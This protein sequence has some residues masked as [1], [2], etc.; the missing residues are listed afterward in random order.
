[1]FGLVWIPDAWT[2]RAISYSSEHITEDSPSL[3][4]Q[5]HWIFIYLGGEGKYG[6]PIM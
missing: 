2:R 4:A 5:L 6:Q 1:M 3:P